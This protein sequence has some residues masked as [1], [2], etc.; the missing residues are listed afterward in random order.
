MRAVLQF[1]FAVLLACVGGCAYR[2]GPT[3][4]ERSGARS[5]QV[6]PFENKTIEPRLVEAVTFALRKQLQQDGTYKLNT[7]DEGDIIVSGAI[8]TYERHSLSFQS[9]DAL[10]PRDYRLK[11]TAHVTA[12]E[13]GSGKVLL[14]TRVNGHSDIRIGP[15]LAS[16]EREALPLVAADLARNT[17]AL[18]VDGSW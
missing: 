7:H 13:R 17:T 5:V 6:N 11:I 3:N 16:A 10:T 4:G 8:V 1:G 14:D 2:L 9:R 18:L 12:R 15:D